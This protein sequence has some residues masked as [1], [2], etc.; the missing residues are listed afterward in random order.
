MSQE[1]T[2]LPAPEPTLDE[3]IHAYLKALDEGRTPDR[4]ALLDGHPALAGELQAF[5]AAQD[6]AVSMAAPLR[7]LITEKTVTEPPLKRLGNYEVIGEIGR[8][9]M[10]MVYKSWQ[11]GADRLAALKVIRSDR[12][13][14]LS[15][16]KL[17]EWL[18]RFRVEGR[19]AAALVHDNIVPIYE[20][21]EIDGR[22]FYS[23][24]YVDGQSLAELIRQAPLANHQAATCL[25]AVARAVHYAHEH[26]IVHRDLKPD[27]I[28]IDGQGRPYVTDFG[29][30]KW[31]GAA[32]DLTHTG[33]VLGSPPYMSPEQARDAGQA[34]VASDVYSLGATLYAALTGRPP[35]QAADPVATL[36]QVLEQDPVPPRRLNPAIARDLETICLKCLS[37]EPQKRYPSAEAL[38]DDLERWLRGEPVRARRTG[39]VVRSLK[40]ARRRP[41]LAG[42]VVLMALTALLGFVG[43]GALLQLRQTQVQRDEAEDARHAEAQ[44]KQEAEQAKLRAEAAEELSQQHLNINRVMRA[45]FEWLDSGVERANQLLDECPLNR[46]RWEWHYVKRLCNTEL[47]TLT[48][49]TSGVSCVAFSP[50]GRRIA[51]GNDDQVRVC[52]SVTGKVSLTLTLKEQGISESVFSMCFSPDGKGLATAGFS[53]LQVWDTAT[54]KAKLRLRWSGLCVCFSPDG[55]RLAS[56][57]AKDA[58][59]RVW[60]AATGRQI[61]T[62]PADS[63]CVCFSHDG[64]RLASGCADGAVCVWDA[65]T[66]QEVLAFKAH[67]RSVSSLS[68]SPDGKKLASAGD[69]WVVRLWDAATGKEVARDPF[70]G[71]GAHTLRGHTGPVGSVCFSP[72][73]KWLASA[74]T[75]GVVRLWDTATGDEARTFRG[76]NGPINAVCFSPDG[77]RMASAGDDQVVRIWDAAACQGPLTLNSWPDVFDVCFSPDSKRLASAGHQVGQDGG[78]KVWDAATGKEAIK[79]ESRGFPTGVP[80]ISV[81]FSAD[82]QRVASTNPGG[83]DVRIWDADTGH[84]I[85]C[86]HTEY[87]SFGVGSGGHGLDTL[88]FS[89]DGRRLAWACSGGVVMVW[90]TATGQEALCLKGSPSRQ[91]KLSFSPDGHRLAATDG[92]GLRICDTIHGQE[93]LTLPGVF[94]AVFSPDGKRLAAPHGSRVVLWDAATGREVFAFKEHSEPILDVAFSPDGQRLASGSVSGK[95][96]VWD[97]ATGQEALTLHCLARTPYTVCTVYRVCFSPDGNR[98]AA[99]CSQGIVQVWDATPLDEKRR[100]VAPGK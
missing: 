78:I 62:I 4:Q 29:L 64:T 40:W 39:P 77:K 63:T 66:G 19:A 79:L 92:D 93:I 53:M 5:F 68:F 45:Q 98:L 96:R 14:D 99:A 7:T 90:D 27:N 47:L 6:R 100:Q 41:A 42:M 85:M 13:V 72:D 1:P 43:V 9:G 97:V 36:R 16:E 30:A 86:L 65:A 69:D 76:H 81:C 73:G 37:K 88:R 83:G 50:D 82:G 71:K 25:E 28:L 17:R 51:S 46:R 3:I 57:G 87:R 23:M 94:D 54:G 60:D 95:V 20:V 91:T 21:D 70:T 61:R 75:D 32:R 67:A 89:P 49:H 8:G 44:A 52:D 18:E 74:G 11:H 80:G 55:K 58:G 33:A 35:F 38:A 26:G 24:Q 56:A 48:G 22:L 59:V 84:E 10:G 15:E 2:T 31:P 12:L 34:T